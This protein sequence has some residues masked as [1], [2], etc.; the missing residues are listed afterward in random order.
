M[1]V[2]QPKKTFLLT[3]LTFAVAMLAF[4]GQLGADLTSVQP[5]PETRSARLNRERKER[6]AKYYE[7]IEGETQQ[8]E[9]G[10]IYDDKT[11]RLE[12]GNGANTAK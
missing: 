1:T 2:V 3:M 7:K 4:L 9:K 6:G 10:A 8:Q 5:P 12:D 11:E